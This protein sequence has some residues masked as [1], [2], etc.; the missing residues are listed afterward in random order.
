MASTCTHLLTQL[1]FSTKNWEALITNSL[2]PELHAYLAAIINGEGGR[3]LAVG[4]V[5]DHIHILAKMPHAISVSDIMRRIKGNS[6]RWLNA[7]HKT[8][9]RFA[10][11]AGFGAF[12][13][14]HSQK[15]PVA[16]YIRNQKEHHRKRSFKEEFV[17]FLQ[18]HEVEYDENHLWK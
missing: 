5:S 1:V 2:E 17:E 10:W 7:N 13:V 12:S 4:G 14:S 3:T 8:P 11:Q 9:H 16:D 6:S 18:R 15:Q